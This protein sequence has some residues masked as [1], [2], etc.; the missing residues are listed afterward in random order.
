MLVIHHNIKLDSIIVDGRGNAELIDF[1]LAVTFSYDTISEDK[2][3]VFVKF[4]RFGDDQFSL[5]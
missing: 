4:R 1:G 3:R 2:C 5:L